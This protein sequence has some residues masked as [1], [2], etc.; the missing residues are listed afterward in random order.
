MWIG[1]MKANPGEKHGKFI[2]AEGVEFFARNG[3]DMMMMIIY[4]LS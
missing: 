4:K 1:W 2:A 3:N